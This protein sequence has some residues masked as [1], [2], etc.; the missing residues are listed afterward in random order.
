MQPYTQ[1]FYKNQSVGSRRS[2]EAIVPLVLTLVKPQSVIDIGCG[3]GT[4]LSVFEKF[5]V[6]DVFGIDGDHVN[7]SM[8][9]IPNERFTAFDLKKRIQID[10]RFDLV[11]SL[12]VAEHLPEQ[13]AKTFV[14]SLTKLGP[15]ILFSAA[16]PFQGGTAHLNEQWPDYWANYF[17]EDGYEVVDYLRKKVWQDDKV[18]WWYAQNI[19]LFSQK[20][21]LASNPLLKKEFENTHPSQLSIVHPRKYLELIWI[22][23]TAQ[24]IANLV[25]NE[26]KFILVDQE[27]LRESMALGNRAIPFLERSGQY[28]GPPPDD[29]TAIRELTRLRQTGAKY[30][31][32]AWPAF[33]WLEYYTEFHH[34]LRLQYHCVLKNERLVVFDLGA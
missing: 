26:D 30:L 20:D 19:L 10:R 9:Q 2:A 22:Q 12:E 25:R 3:L 27:Q 32:F 28:W 1:E 31:V 8:L 13:C 6:K 14:H 24:D 34:K 18:E 17:S 4:W 29:D 5:G 21:Y 23:L 7:R 33:W 16:I 15:V 11:I